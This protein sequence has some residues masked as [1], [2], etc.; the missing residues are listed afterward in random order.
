MRY[1]LNRG[2][3]TAIGGWLRWWRKWHRD[4]TVCV[5][6]AEVLRRNR[7]QLRK[8]KSPRESKERE[9]DSQLIRSWVEKPEGK[10]YRQKRRSRKRKKMLISRENIAQDLGG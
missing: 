4:R 3:G 8:V 7:V 6:K 5:R 10:K 9:H 2:V 1:V